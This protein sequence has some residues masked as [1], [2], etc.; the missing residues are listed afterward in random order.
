VCQLTT[1]IN[2][3]YESANVHL[4]VLY[5]ELADV[6]SHGFP[7]LEVLLDGRNYALMGSRLI[8]I[9]DLRRVWSSRRG[10]SCSPTETNNRKEKN[11]REQ[12]NDHGSML[13]GNERGQTR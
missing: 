13:R 2:V 3:W 9:V 7:P 6:G 4:H 11:I 5:G 1:F 12:I 10:V 8:I